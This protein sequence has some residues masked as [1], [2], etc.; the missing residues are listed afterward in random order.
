MIV[1]EQSNRPLSSLFR[2]A[3]ISLLLTGILYGP[4]AAVAAPDVMAIVDQMKAVFEPPRPSIRKVEITV[5][6]NEGQEEAEWTAGIARKQL[7]DGKRSLIVMLEPQ[8]VRGNALLL[9]EREKQADSM[10]VYSPVLRRVRR[11]VPV[12]AYEHFMDTDFT[13]ADLGFVS[14]RGTYR[15][16]GEEEH[17]GVHAY[18]IEEAPKE[19]WYYSR[20]VTWVNAD[21]LLPLQRDYYDTAGR[22][23]KTV[24]FEQVSII[25]GVPTPLRLR[26]QDLQQDTSTELTMS[27]VRYDA[28]LPEALFEPSGLPQVATSPLWQ[29][30]RTQAT[31]DT[32]G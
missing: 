9:W 13:Y 29:P 23:W 26:M 22:L 14:R 12:D 7:A 31:A 5:S 3:L 10:V 11:I 18:K 25:D 19:Q 6:N 4:R 17:A 1:Q 30:Y 16:L 15:L 8:S 20:T 2:V 27:E 32:E 28:D 21:S 24:L